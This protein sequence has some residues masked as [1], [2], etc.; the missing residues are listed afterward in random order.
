M[1]CSS[2]RVPQ[3][4]KELARSIAEIRGAIAALPAPPTADP[5]SD[6]LTLLHTFMQAA[7]LEIQGVP[8]GV[9]SA[10]KPGLIQAIRPEHETFKR[11]VRGTAPCFI[12]FESTSA[13]GLMRAPYFLKE[14]EGEYYETDRSGMHTGSVREIY[15]DEV[16]RRAQQ[17]VYF[18][19]NVRYL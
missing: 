4:T 1:S 18:L 15:I 12:P 9:G 7:S 17:Y 10:T 5:R 19:L 13:I 14:E 16:L 11:A 6:I 8:D 3:I 2:T